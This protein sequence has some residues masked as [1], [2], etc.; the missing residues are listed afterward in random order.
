MAPREQNTISRQIRSLQQRYVFTVFIQEWLVLKGDDSDFPMDISLRVKGR[1]I[2]LARG[3]RE[4][5][6]IINEKWEVGLSLK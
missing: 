2:E 4:K 5:S 3:I 1:E 6:L